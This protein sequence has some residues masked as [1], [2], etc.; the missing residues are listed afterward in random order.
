MSKNK[1]N[2]TLYSF[3][4]DVEIFKWW[5]TQDFQREQGEQDYTMIFE[6]DLPKIIKAFY[7]YFWKLFIAEGFVTMHH[8][9]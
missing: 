2:S 9:I 6:I 3:P 7:E 5:E 1:T 8:E 4:S